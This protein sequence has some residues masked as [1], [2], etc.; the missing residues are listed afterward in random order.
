M[1]GKP[2]AV[3]NSGFDQASDRL[4]ITYYTDPLCC[5]SWAFEPQ[6]RK[7]LYVFSGQIRYRYC[8]GGLLPGWK[9]YNDSVNSV[10]KP[11]QMGPVWMHAAQLSGMPIAHNIWMTDPPVSS[12]LT[13]IAV[14]CAGLQSPKSEELYLRLLRE[15]V[16]IRGENISKESVLL[17]IANELSE[18][19]Q[20]FSKTQFTEDLKNDKGLEVFRKDLQE[21]QYHNINRFPSLVV[22]NKMSQAIIISGYRSYS[23]LLNAIEQLG[24]LQKNNKKIEPEDYK[25]FWLSLTDRELQEIA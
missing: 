25:D 1:T 8:M 17:S 24:E 18:V 6:W 22:K 14:K 19:M 7:L 23:L 21:V 12:Y 4:E 15:A 13:C 20:E 9:N 16:M 10:S 2:I 3:N 11:I 5:W